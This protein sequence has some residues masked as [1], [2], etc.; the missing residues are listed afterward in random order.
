MKLFGHLTLGVTSLFVLVT[1]LTVLGCN[2]SSTDSSTK[3]SVD[4]TV[5]DPS[6][7][8]TLAID[9]GALKGT[10]LDIPADALP[11]GAKVTLAEG[12]PP[13]EF[14]EVTSGGNSP[15][16]AVAVLTIVDKTGKD[17]VPAAPLTLAIPISNDASLA[18]VSIEQVIENIVALLK[19]YDAKLYIWLNSGFSSV[20]ETKKLVKIMTL[21]GGTYR[22][23]YAAQT[24]P[25]G[26]SD[27][28]MTTVSGGPGID[29]TALGC[30]GEK[31]NIY[32]KIKDSATFKEY[33]DALQ[34]VCCKTKGLS[35]D[36]CKSQI[37]TYLSTG[38][39]VPKEAENAMTAES[40]N[41]SFSKITKTINDTNCSGS[42]YATG[43]TTDTETSSETSTETGSGTGTGTETSTGASTG[44]VRFACDVH[45][46][47]SGLAPCMA[48]VGSYYT[49]S[50]VG[51]CTSGTLINPGD[52]PSGAIGKCELDVG[53]INEVWNYYYPSVL[54]VSQ[55]QESCQE[56]G[57]VWVT[58]QDVP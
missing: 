42:S 38:L 36:D 26:F 55:I 35:G 12:D 21:M 52:C 40:L 7:P 56:S 39:C 33:V 53:A 1:V 2:K 58:L 48:F 19:T 3:A 13:A 23:A 18:L 16:S 50:N 57:G 5:A 32:D 44:S 41:D 25:T 27:V 9:S 8:L 34:N 47:T 29:Y 45:V 46:S 22:L 14:N 4:K 15:A 10:S 28:S 6:Q 31:V 49:T 30:T 54:P 24:V 43:T 51:G 17:I 37:Q 20:D 11:E